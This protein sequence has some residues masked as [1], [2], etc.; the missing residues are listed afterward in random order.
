MRQIGNRYRLQR[1]REGENVAA[2][3]NA[4]MTRRTS[5]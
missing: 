1:E 4:K 3:F 5:H 2:D